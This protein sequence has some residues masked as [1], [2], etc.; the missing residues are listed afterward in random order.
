LTDDPLDSLSSFDRVSIRAVLARDGEDP[1]AALAAAGI[2]DP[3]AIPVI[4]GDDPHPTGGI[5]GDGITPNLIAMPETKYEGGFDPLPY[6]QQLVAQR[7]TAAKPSYRS[8]TRMLPAAFGLRPLAPIPTI[9]RSGQYLDA[10]TLH[11]VD[12]TSGYPPVPR[13][14]LPSAS[15][16]DSEGINVSTDLG[17]LAVKPNGTASDSHDGYT[18]SSEVALARANPN[19]TVPEP[20]AVLPP[21]FIPRMSENNDVVHSIIEGFQALR[22]AAASI[23][24]AKAPQ[25]PQ[26]ITNPPQASPPIP[27]GWVS[28]PAGS[29]VINSPPGQYPPASGESIRVMPPGSTPVPGLENGYWRQTNKYGQ[30][31]NPATG[32][33]GTQGQTHVPLPLAK[34]S[35]EK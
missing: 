14:L 25:R 15:L 22:V 1:S 3:I 32:G 7:G 2:F 19:I 16:G 30:P 8:G 24:N 35:P 28:S 20:P 10:S 11:E 17:Q 4:I 26:P 23:A 18:R 21:V 29:G 5:L 12:R 27:D 34:P 31:I 6:R 33:T 13:R 9:S